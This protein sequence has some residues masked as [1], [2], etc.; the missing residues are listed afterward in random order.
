MG[1]RFSGTCWYSCVACG[2]QCAERQAQIWRAASLWK[3]VFPSPFTLGG[4]NT[5]KYENSSSLSPDWLCLTKPASNTVLTAVLGTRCAQSHMPVP[6]VVSSA[7]AKAQGLHWGG[8]DGGGGGMWLSH[9]SAHASAKLGTKC[10]AGERGVDCDC[11][12]L[13]P[14]RRPAAHRGALGR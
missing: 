2:L 11:R 10:A 13:C 8:R 1:Q 12:R 4:H 6:G 9:Q 7:G 3:A 14:R 5:N